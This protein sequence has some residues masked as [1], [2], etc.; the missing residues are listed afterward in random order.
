MSC[1]REIGGST[2]SREGSHKGR[3]QDV[4]REHG[5][6]GWISV[7]MKVQTR[8]LQAIFEW[9]SFEE[10]KWVGTVKRY[11]RPCVWTFGGLVQRFLSQISML[12][13]WDVM[14]LRECFRKLDG[15]IGGAHELFTLGELVGDCDAQQSSNIRDG[16]DKRKLLGE[17]ADGKLSSWM[18]S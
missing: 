14:L 5:R 13:D 3:H 8:I 10:R 16:L 2:G 11:Y 7:V 1:T 9:D 6:V 18:D 4:R 15:V 17:Q 12:A